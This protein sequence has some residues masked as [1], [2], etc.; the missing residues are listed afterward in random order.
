MA[1]ADSFALPQAALPQTRPA[2][3]T[4]ADEASREAEVLLI[5]E[6]QAGSRAASSSKIA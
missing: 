2:P 6:A 5:R 3:R 1:S 4:L